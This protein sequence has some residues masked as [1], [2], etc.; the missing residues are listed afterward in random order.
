M[1]VMRRRAALIVLSMLGKADPD[2]INKNLELFRQIGLQE[3]GKTDVSLAK[4]VC[5]AFQQLGVSK[6]AKGSTAAPHER[7]S[8][9]HPLVVNLRD[10]ILQPCSSLDW[11]SISF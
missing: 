6:R 1:P 9:Q 8:S 5:I 2:I 10:L 3:F 4:Y 7:Y 11:Y